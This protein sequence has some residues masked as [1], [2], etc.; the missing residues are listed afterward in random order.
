MTDPVYYKLYL[1]THT[2]QMT[3]VC[4]Q[5]F[6]EP[7]YPAER[8]FKDENGHDYR[9]DEEEAAIAFLNEKFKAEAIEEECRRGRSRRIFWTVL[10]FQTRL[11]LGVRTGTTLTTAQM[12]TSF[13]RGGRC[14]GPV[15]GR[16]NT[17]TAR[18]A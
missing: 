9:F 6:D 1:S 4:M 8:F 12:G 5:S 3:V 2:G 13:S 11:P 17:P 10:G 7:D 16:K 15:H 18:A 14:R